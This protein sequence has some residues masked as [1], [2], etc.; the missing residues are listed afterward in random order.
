[1]LFERS[2]QY[3]ERKYRI[4]NISFKKYFKRKYRKCIQ[5]SVMTV[6]ANKFKIK[7]KI[8]LKSF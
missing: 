6:K 7:F 2:I 1:M 4:K 8:N 3:S 5:L